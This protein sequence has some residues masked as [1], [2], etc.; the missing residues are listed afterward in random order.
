MMIDLFFP[1]Q[2][3]YGQL[4]N[5]GNYY[6]CTEASSYQQYPKM[7]VLNNNR[8]YDIVCSDQC[9]FTMIMSM[10][11]IKSHIQDKF[12]LIFQS[13]ITSGVTEKLINLRDYIK[14]E[15]T[16]TE[17]VYKKKSIVNINEEFKFQI[18]K[19]ISQIV[20]NLTNELIQHLDEAIK[21]SMSETEKI[22]CIKQQIE[23]LLN[24]QG[25]INL[26]N[27][28]GHLDLCEQDVKKYKVDEMIKLMEKLQQVKKE[29][30]QILSEIKI[31]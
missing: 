1:Q 29:I 21:F 31:E 12:D 16:L 30:N 13:Q 14:Q 26:L 27:H 4:L 23:K 25:N 19:S 10:N 20:D 15:V 8:S 17:N 24:D 2:L 22:N 6:Y 9:S 28:K 11:N 5:I 18:S 7:L 3:I